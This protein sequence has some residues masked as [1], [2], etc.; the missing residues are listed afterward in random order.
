MRASDMSISARLRLGFGLIMA[1][2]V[3]AFELD[4]N[5]ALPHP[6]LTHQEEAD[7]ARHHA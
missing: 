4:D 7:H 2:P 1:L 5:A 6:T 3:R